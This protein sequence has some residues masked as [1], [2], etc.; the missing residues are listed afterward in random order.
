MM[1]STNGGSSWSQLTY[2]TSGYG[3]PV[4]HS[5]HHAIA[6]DPVTANVVY[7]GDDG[8]IQKT[9]N[10]GTSWTDQTSGTSGWH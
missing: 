9:T 2:W 3:T 5:D 1:K 10:G 4:V 7:A 8:G 6:F